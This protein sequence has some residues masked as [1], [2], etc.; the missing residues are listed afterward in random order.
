M[1]TVRYYLNLSS[2]N[3]EEQGAGASGGTV[4]WGCPPPPRKVQSL[5]FF[6]GTGASQ[7][8]RSLGPHTHHLSPVPLWSRF[9]SFTPQKSKG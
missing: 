2:L 7:C 6:L 1:N 8:S 4:R 9:P 3:G 5:R